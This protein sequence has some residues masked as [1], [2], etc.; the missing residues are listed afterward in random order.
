[1]NFGIINFNTELPTGFAVDNILR[2]NEQI[3]THGLII[4][5]RQAVAIA[6]A[7]STALKSNGRMEFGGETIKKL[8]LSFS[9]SPFLCQD[10]FSDTVCELIDIFYHYKNETLDTI[11]DDELISIMRDTFDGI[12]GG[13]LEFLSSTVLNMLS[14]QVK[15]MDSMDTQNDEQED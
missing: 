3:S 15:G 10:N 2:C 9:D 8:I 13:D 14:R 4:S 11:S 1:M 7:N 12:C 5:E 6:E